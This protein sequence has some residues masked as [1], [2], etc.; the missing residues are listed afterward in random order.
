MIA[1]KIL[2]IYGM[3]GSLPTELETEQQ[4]TVQPEPAGEP[5]EHS[6]TPTLQWWAAAHTTR[7]RYRED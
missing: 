5:Y 1:H 7:V 2:K 4:A 3:E 6:C